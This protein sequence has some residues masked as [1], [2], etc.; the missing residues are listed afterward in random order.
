MQYLNGKYTAFVKLIKG[1]GTLRQ[2]ADTPIVPNASGEMSKPQ[3]RVDVISIKIV[4]RD[5]VK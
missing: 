2:I 3:K 4:P 1:D 5:T